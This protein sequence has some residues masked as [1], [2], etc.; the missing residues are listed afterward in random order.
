MIFMNILEQVGSKACTDADDKIL[1]PSA[2]LGYMAVGYTTC[3]MYKLKCLLY[4]NVRGNVT[5]WTGWQIR[6]HHCDPA[7]ALFLQGLVPYLS[8]YFPCSFK[9]K[10]FTRILKK[11]KY[12]STRRYKPNENILTNKENHKLY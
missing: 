10:K 7:K 3:T 8:S 11:R 4:R 9:Y 1:Y 12:F 6:S 5:A 2:A